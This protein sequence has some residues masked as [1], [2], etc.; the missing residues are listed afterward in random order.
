MRRQWPEVLLMLCGASH[1]S[2]PEVHQWCESQ[3]PVVFYILGQSG[4][5]VLKRQAAG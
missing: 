1:L 5:A 3:E 2:T 4:N